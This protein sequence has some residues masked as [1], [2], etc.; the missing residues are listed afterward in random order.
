MKRRLDSKKVD[1]GLKLEMYRKMV[2]IRMKDII[3]GMLVGEVSPE[4]L[5]EEVAKSIEE[6]R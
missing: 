4:Q 2:E 1:R 3:D 6:N 5:A